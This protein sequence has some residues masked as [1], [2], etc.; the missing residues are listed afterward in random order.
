MAVLGSGVA[1][2]AGRAGKSP[3][4]VPMSLVSSG[5]ARRRQSSRNELS[6]NQAPRGGSLPA[7]AAGT[8]AGGAE[9]M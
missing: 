7:C 3:G 5:P 8:A 6:L 4:T 1:V 2:P 9:Y